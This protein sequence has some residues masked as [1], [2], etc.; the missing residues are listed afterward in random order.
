MRRLVWTDEC[1]TGFSEIDSQHR[2]LFAIAN[3]LLEI[4][5]PHKQQDEIKYLLH[6]LLEY[7]E[8][9]FKT[10]EEIFEKNKYPGFREHKERHET[11][12]KDISSTIKAAKSM[13]ELKASLD[14]MLENWIRVHV[15]LEDKK[16]S[17]WFN[18]K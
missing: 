2:L 7:T 18:S 10:E 15:L 4:N 1:K 6:H 12:L 14:T 9:H 8:T 17:V 5:N 11:I 13:T 16:F 3:E